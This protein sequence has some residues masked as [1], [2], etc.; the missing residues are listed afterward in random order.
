MNISTEQKLA[1]LQSFEKGGAL[2]PSQIFFVP[3][4]SHYDSRD[5]RTIREFCQQLQRDGYLVP[6]QDHKES[7]TMPPLCLSNSG[8]ELLD[9]LRKSVGNPHPGI[10][11]EPKLP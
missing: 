1:I 10:A 3:N 5:V 4:L 7:R 6:A 11:E 8:R 2:Y 9:Q